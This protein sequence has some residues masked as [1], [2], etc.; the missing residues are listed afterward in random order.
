M[1]L[2]HDPSEIS[3]QV[4]LHGFAVTDGI[5][6][7]DELATFRAVAATMPEARDGDWN[8]CQNPHSSSAEFRT[9]MAKPALLTIV[10]QCVGGPVD[11]LQSQLMYGAPGFPGYGL[12]QDNNYIQ[13]APD[14]F[15]TAWT[16]L[17][18][19]GPQNGGLILYDG[20]HKEPILPMSQSG[21]TGPI[22]IV[23]ESVI[24]P[25]GRYPRIEIEIKPG[26]VAFLHS[27]LVHGSMPNRTPDRFRLSFLYTYLRQGEDFRAGYGNKRQRIP[28]RG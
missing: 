26:E 8:I 7:V 2:Y 14:A 4:A 10:E 15:I 5:W 21:A 22:H 9:G 13:T 6:S 28:L 25:E 12:H 23:Q 16:A 27:H 19:A 17:D 24:L 20:S 18:V 1:T 3:R 11:G